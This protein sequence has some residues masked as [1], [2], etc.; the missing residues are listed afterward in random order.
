MQMAEVCGAAPA[1]ALIRRW[2]RKAL[3]FVTSQLVP[4]PQAQAP[5]AT[6]CDA[7]A[8]AAAAGLLGGML[9]ERGSAPQATVQHLI[10]VRNE[11]S[12]SF[13]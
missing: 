3:A 2:L 8:A 13:F 7:A 12:T 11:H 10:K 6:D 4:Q 5:S 9:P 1:A